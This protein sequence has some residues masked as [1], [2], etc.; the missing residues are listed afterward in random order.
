MKKIS[1]SEK[2]E[3]IWGAMDYAENKIAPMHKHQGYHYI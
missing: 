1:K 3:I 2:N